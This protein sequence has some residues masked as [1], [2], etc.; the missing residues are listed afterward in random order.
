MMSC[1]PRRGFW[2]GLIIIGQG[3][4][5]EGPHQGNATRTSGTEG[6]SGSRVPRK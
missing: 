1:K 6:I 2:A 3:P 4:R 5:Q